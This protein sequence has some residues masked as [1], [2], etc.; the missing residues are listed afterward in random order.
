MEGGPFQFY[1]SSGCKADH[2]LRD[3]GLFTGGG[4]AQLLNHWSIKGKFGGKHLG[5]LQEKE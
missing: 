2:N 3:L 4:A 5:L 1:F